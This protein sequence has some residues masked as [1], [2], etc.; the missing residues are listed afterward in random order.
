MCSAC[1]IADCSYTW[2]LPGRVLDN[3]S[4]SLHVL[5]ASRTW[6]MA[7]IVCSEYQYWF[8]LASSAVLQLH[9]YMATVCVDWCKI[10]PRSCPVQNFVLK[11][12]ELQNSDRCKNIL[13]LDDLASVPLPS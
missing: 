13:G 7:S 5:T 9:I 2:M 8:R 6:I 3:V 11:G 12:R 4:K 10:G 1:T